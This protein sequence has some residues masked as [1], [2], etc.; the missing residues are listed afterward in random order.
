MERIKEEEES[1]CSQDSCRPSPSM[2]RACSFQ[3]QKAQ[4]DLVVSSVLGALRGLGIE[5]A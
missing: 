5:F 1:S 3:E 4:F 2:K